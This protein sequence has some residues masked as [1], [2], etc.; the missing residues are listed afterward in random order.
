VP[1]AGHYRPI[2]IHAVRNDAFV[3]QLGFVS[4]NSTSLTFLTALRDAGYKT[5]EAWIAEHGHKVGERSSVDV[6]AE[7]TDKMLKAPR[8]RI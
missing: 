4:K 2:R 3:E 5:A 8:R 1:Y 6:K 7:F